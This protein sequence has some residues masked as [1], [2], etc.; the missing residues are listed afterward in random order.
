MGAV[1]I[2]LLLSAFLGI[3]GYSFKIT[4]ILSNIIDRHGKTSEE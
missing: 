2:F 1:D 4:D 3:S